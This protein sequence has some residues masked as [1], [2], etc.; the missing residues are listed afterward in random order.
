MMGLRALMK[1][2]KRGHCPTIDPVHRI[3]PHGKEILENGFQ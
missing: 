1:L 2:L 3:T